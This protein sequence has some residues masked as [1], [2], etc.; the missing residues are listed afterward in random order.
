MKG[1]DNMSKP[2]R[3]TLVNNTIDSKD[4]SRYNPFSRKE[5][6]DRDTIFLIK[7]LYEK[8]IINE[9][10]YREICRRFKEM[11]GIY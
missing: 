6:V 8:K 7:A 4:G 2:E 11:E 10:T 5:K 3:D 9:A 1:C